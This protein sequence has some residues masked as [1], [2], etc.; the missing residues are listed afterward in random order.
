MSNQAKYYMLATNSVENNRS[1]I[2]GCSGDDGRILCG[3]NVSNLT[4]T[5]FLWVDEIE[6]GVTCKR[7]LIIISRRGYLPAFSPNHLSTIS[8]KQ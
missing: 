1:Q 7:C 5:Q 3:A 8:K 2:H 6:C 4:W